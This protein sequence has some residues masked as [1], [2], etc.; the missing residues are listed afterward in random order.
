MNIALILVH[1]KGALGNA[2]QVTELTALL[3]PESP[4]SNIYTISDSD[5]RFILIEIV[6]KD[7][8]PPSHSLLFTRRVIYGNDR[9]GTDG[10]FFNFGLSRGIDYLY[11]DAAIYI[12]N[13]TTLS[14][15]TIEAS[16]AKLKENKEF[17]ENETFGKVAT[18]RFFQA[19]R[20]ILDDTKTLAEA[21]TRYKTRASQEGLVNG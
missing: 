13:A 17:L 1:D 18:R 6:P 10:N 4:G 20:P 21:V 19:I 5:H 3:T 16:L 8:T 7:V 12:E 9:P 11:A 2:T 14:R 15:V